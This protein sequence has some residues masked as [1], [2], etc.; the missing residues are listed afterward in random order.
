MTFEPNYKHVQDAAYNHVPQRLP[1]YEHLIADSIMEAVLEKEF[2]SL[3]GGSL[4]DKEEYFTHVCN[5]CKKLGY[6][7]LS[8][9]CCIGGIL[10]NG[11]LL[12]GQGTSVIRSY[13]DFEKYPWDGLCDMY[14][15]AFGPNF[16][17]LGKAFPPGM[18]A[19]GGVGHGVFEA[20][21]EIMGYEHLACMKYDD[22]ELYAA[23][24]N[25]MG[26]ISLQIWTRFMQEYSEHYCVLRF[27]DDLGFKTNTLLS[28]DDIRRH[29]IPQYKKIVDLVH[30]YNKPFLLHSCGYLF[31][32][33][34]DLI[35]DAGI[36]AKHSNEDIIG[37][38]PVWVEKYGSQIGNFGGI[39]TDA[40]CGLS[41]TQVRE[42]V[43]DVLN[44]CA[45]YE[46]AGGI[47]F[48]SGNSIPG[49]VDVNS[50]VEMTNAV[51][52]YRGEFK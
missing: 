17:A 36:N 19:V 26:D 52:V 21:Q 44:E 4:R 29:I 5:F 22:P 39:D 15:N 30:S 51:R 35:R 13:E 16:E 40:I 31:D 9:E 47:A 43:N 27:G 50:Y 2:S 41:T 33:M 12:G 32:V 25:K 48:G 49:Y 18:K 38:F 11:G 6:D 23:L 24:F 42:Y 7:A 14:F 1:L 46:Y 34:P 20:V 37:R 45:Q 10:P 8:F 3:Q 28:A